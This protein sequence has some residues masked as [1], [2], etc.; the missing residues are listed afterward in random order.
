[1]HSVTPWS[2]TI[3]TVEIVANR[4]QGSH[5]LASLK[6]DWALVDEQ[7]GGSDSKEG[8]GKVPVGWPIEERYNRLECAATTRPALGYAPARPRPWHV[9]RPDEVGTVRPRPACRYSGSLESTTPPANGA[10]T[11]FVGTDIRV[12][13]SSAGGV[14]VYERADGGA[15][16]TEIG[17][18]LTTKVALERDDLE[19]MPR[20]ARADIERAGMR[21]KLGGPATDAGSQR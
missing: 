6:G 8:K 15:V 13:R 4:I 19:S 12:V 10:V 17:Q 2:Q 7:P 1:M 3:Q 5:N 20:W 18:L 16:Q 14:S 9:A 11:T 21:G